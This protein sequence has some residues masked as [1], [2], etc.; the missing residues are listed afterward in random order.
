ASG[1]TAALAARMID[2]VGVHYLHCRIVNDVTDGTL[3]EFAVTIKVADMGEN[4]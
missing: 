2:Q 1:G 4:A 3:S